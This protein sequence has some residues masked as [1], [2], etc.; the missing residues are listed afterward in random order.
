LRVGDEQL[1][2]LQGDADDARLRA[3]VAE[4]PVA[5]REH[6]EARRHAEAM[7]AHLAAVRDEMSRLE[8]EQDRLLDRL[9]EG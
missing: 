1:L 5:E 4:M 6:V 3:L 7:V 9:S 8:Q 2:Q